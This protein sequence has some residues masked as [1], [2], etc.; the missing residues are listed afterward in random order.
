[1]KQRIAIIGSTGSI[2]NS[3]LSLIK[4][5]K[6]NIK[7]VFLAANTNFK[8]LLYQ[9]KQFNVRNIIITNHKCYK[10]ALT[11]NK[12]K[13][14]KIFNSFDSLK[15]IIDKK[16][17]YVMSAFSGIDGLKPTFKIIKYTRKIAIANKESIICAWPIL[18]KE[19]TRYKTEFIPVDSEH[20]SIWSEI[21]NHNIKK[22]KRI[23]LTASGGPLLNIKSKRVD[24]VD[25]TQ[26][27]KHPT[28][29]MGKKISVDSA[30]MMNKCFEIMEA[31][32]IF[33]IS[34][35]KINIIIHPDS[36]AHAII[37]YNNGLFKIIFHDTTMKIPIF[38][39]I[40]SKNEIYTPNNKLNYNKLNNLKFQ[41]ISIKKFPAINIMRSLP[42]KHSMF[43]TI[44]VSVNDTVVDSYLNNKI[45]FSKI[46]KMILN[47]ANKKE[48]KK[49]KK[50][51]PK[52]IDEIINLNKI[53]KTKISEFIK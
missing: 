7:I 49:Y 6:K 48:F 30:T 13:K 31:K 40:F 52:S 14:I 16:L 47:F 38:N 39:T 4:R 12:D 3:L 45:K 1:M 21:K 19:L 41:N 35:Q 36:Y 18:K 33:D 8:S 20:F 24:D 51:Y 46:S 27:L 28:W 26:I 53:V 9:A 37:E 15:K 10:N 22:I 50:I 5:K 43:E 11:L 42:I 34:Y 44:L 32:N 29:K 2:G 23:H 25:I 17:D